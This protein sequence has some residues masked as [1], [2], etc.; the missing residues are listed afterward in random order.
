MEVT[1]KIFEESI[2]KSDTRRMRANFWDRVLGWINNAPISYSFY[3]VWYMYKRERRKNS[4]IALTHQE[5]GVFII[6]SYIQVLVINPSQ[7][8]DEEIEIE[9]EVLFVDRLLSSVGIELD[10]TILLDCVAKGMSLR[11]SLQGEYAF[12][13]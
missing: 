5:F 9:T 12:Q 1:L 7:Y 6:N 8:L 4:S 11:K 2:V 13:A 3:T 10:D